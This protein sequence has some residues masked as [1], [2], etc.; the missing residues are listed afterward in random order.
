LIQEKTGSSRS[1]AVLYPHQRWFV[2][3]VLVSVLDLDSLV[4]RGSKPADPLPLEGISTKL[5]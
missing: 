2:A 3:G 4:L 1:K 5:M